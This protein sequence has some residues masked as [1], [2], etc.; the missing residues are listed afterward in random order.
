MKYYFVFLLLLLITLTTFSQ[1]QGRLRGIVSDSTSGEF[2]PYANI[3]IDE[4]QTGASTD[5]RGLYLINQIPGDQTYTVIISFVG[6]QTKTIDV[7]I[8]PNKLTQLDVELVPQDIELGSV[9]KIGNKV[10]EKNTTD[11]GL[12]RISVKALQSL[13]KGVETDV[14]R[15]LQYVSGVRSTGDVTAK[16]YVRGGTSDQNLVKLNG[17]TLYNPFHALGLFSVIDPEMINSVEFYKGGFTAEYGTR[18][19]SVLS[20]LTKDGNRNN[21]SATASTS[22]LTNKLLLEGPIPNGS[23]ILTGRKSFSNDILKKFLNDENVP[24]DFYDFS[25]KLNYSD[26]NILENGRFYVFGFMSNDDLDD[27]DPLAEDYKWSNNLIGFEWVQIYDVPL[28][29]RL[30]VSLSKFEGEVI[31]NESDYKPRNNE[32][33]DLTLGLDFNYVWPSKD[34]LGFGI[35]FKG[36]STKLVQSNSQGA[37]TDIDDFSGNFSLYAKYKFLRFENFGI[38]IGSRLNLTG[39]TENGGMYFEPR[40]SMTYRAFP[41]L[42]FKAAAGLYQQEVA[43]I[44]DEN[45]VI[46]LFEPWTILPDY[47]EPSRALHLTFGTDWYLA[48]NFLIKYEG[49][50]KKIKNL[51]AVNEDKIY[52]FEQDLINGD[53]E[54]YGSE[55]TVNYSI[56]NLKLNSTYSLSWAYKE[57]DGWLYYPKYDSR[58]S[59][60]IGL[61]YNFGSGWS[62]N[63]VWSYSSGLPFTPLAGYYDK[64]YTGNFFDPDPGNYRFNPYTIL[65][66]RNIGRLPEYHRLDFTLSKKIDLDFLKAELDVSIIN[67]YDRE[68][69]FYFKRDTGEKVNML[70]FLPTATLKVQ[71]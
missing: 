9:E 50:Y 15:S 2:L 59:V 56:G 43:T 44:S 10:I 11:I 57:V 4:I 55:F 26:P 40:I 36:L 51:A 61:E 8:A 6:Y 64:Y 17:I 37:K 71:I 65:G 52:D 21:Y 68:N 47:L 70:P 1:Q 33:S 48:E 18:I 27:K 45:E 25:F 5:E 20:V 66:D 28:F 39:L 31:P 38:D 53:G 13:P 58:H 29:S 12:E 62:A 34:E 42:G 23:F 35:E 24:I 3:F 14:L 46:S 60:N 32:V 7:F 16:Y 22:F 54:A 30:G 19:S 49:Y 67:V 41:F 63:T 69:I